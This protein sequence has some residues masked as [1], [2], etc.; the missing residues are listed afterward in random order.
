MEKIRNRD[1]SLEDK[2]KMH[3]KDF[4]EVVRRG[5]WEPDPTTT[6]YYCSGYVQANLAVIP[7]DMAIEFYN[8]CLRNPRSCQIID[9]CDVGSP[10]P[11]LLP[12]CLIFVKGVCP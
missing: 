3:P 1:L 10:N 8:F 12:N 6:E 5:E 11:P 7:A 9:V 2:E 4:R